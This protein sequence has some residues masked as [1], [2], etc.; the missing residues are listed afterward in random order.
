MAIE[1]FNRPA[2]V[3]ILERIAFPLG[4]AKTTGIMQ[5]QSDKALSDEGSVVLAVKYISKMWDAF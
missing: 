4:L 5:Q 2:G 1:D 3:R